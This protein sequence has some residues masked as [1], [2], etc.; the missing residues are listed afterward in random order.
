MLQ[1][2]KFFTPNGDGENDFWK[3]KGVN[4]NLYKEGS[5]VIF[6]RYGNTVYKGSIFDIGW[7]GFS[8]GYLF[9]TVK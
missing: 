7:N 8:K 6:N 5:L 9:F 4:Q 2:P 1:Y 3:I